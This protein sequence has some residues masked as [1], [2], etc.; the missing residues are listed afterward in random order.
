MF[1][2]YPMSQDRVQFFIVNIQE[3]PSKEKFADSKH[4]DAC[5]HE[6]FYIRKEQV[7]GLKTS[8]YVWR[9]LESSS[10]TRQCLIAC[11]VCLTHYTCFSLQGKLSRDDPALRSINP[12]EPNS[13][14]SHY[15]KHVS[16]E[17]LRGF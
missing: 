14:M 6:N 1:F 5:G 13:V 3:G 2:F 9:E 17:F 11:M 7:S 4:L 10:R 15:D 16:P 8:G 12:L